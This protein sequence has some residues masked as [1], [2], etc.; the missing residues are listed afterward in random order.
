MER[1]EELKLQMEQLAEAG[2]AVAFS[3]GIDSSLLLRLA[4]DSGHP[5]HAVML[6]SQLMPLRDREIA[7]R[8]AAECRTVLTVL[9]T[10][11]S[12]VPEIM[13]NDRRRCYFCKLAMFRRLKEW[14]E[15]RKIPVIADGT[16]ADDLAVYR[17][18]LQAL[19]ELGIRSPL[20]AC[21]ITKKEV[22]QF[23][24]ALGLSVAE[25]PSAPCMATRLPYDTPL[26]FTVLRRLEEGEQ[27][28]K[29]RGFPVCRLRLHGVVLRVEV[30]SERFDE[31]L[32]IR[33]EITEALK[34]LGFTY[35]TLDLEGFRSGSMDI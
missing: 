11:L 1:L 16:N 6:H 14:C 30:P 10:D 33:T 31:L 20:A 32:Q 24:A 22:R 8:V 7:E 5:V 2:L 35:I 9:E 34:K 15:E 4:C 13:T 18:G 28:L 25:R 29:D 3:G 12:D 26:D 17:P 21:G 27:C 23:A 19:R